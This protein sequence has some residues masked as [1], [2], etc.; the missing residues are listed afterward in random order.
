MS[1]VGN[2]LVSKTKNLFLKRLENKF[3][4][5]H[6]VPTKLAVRGKLPIFDKPEVGIEAGETYFISNGLTVFMSEAEEDEVVEI[7]GSAETLAITKGTKIGE[8]HFIP[9]SDSYTW[10]TKTLTIAKGIVGFTDFFKFLEDQS[11]SEN[12][13]LPYP[14]YL[15]GGTNERMANFARRLG[16]KIVKPE[17]GDNRIY[18]IGKTS[19][20]KR[21]LNEYQEKYSSDSNLMT[22]VERESKEVA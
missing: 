13:Q 11:T 5:S 6:T 20:I 18:V 4:K 12:R 21:K 19:E 2:E 14:E 17:K 22:R 15:F 7:K 9:F 8:M 1:E 3:N 16:F 10:G